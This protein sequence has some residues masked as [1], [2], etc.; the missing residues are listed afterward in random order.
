M[1]ILPCWSSGAGGPD[2]LSTSGVTNLYWP[3]R[4]L[5]GIGEAGYYAGECRLT[6]D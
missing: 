6:Y 2:N 3:R 5:L 4:V 1:D